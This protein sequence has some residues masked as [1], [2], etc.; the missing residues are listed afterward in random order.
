MADNVLS[1]LNYSKMMD[2]TRELLT[3]DKWNVIFDKLPPAVYTPGE[4]ALKF[5]LKSVSGLGAQ[6]FGAAPLAQVMV[7][8]FEIPPQPGQAVMQ[9]RNVILEFIDYED[10]SIYAFF[11]DWKAKC[12]NPVNQWSYRAE[13][14]R[15]NLTF[16][17]LNSQN[18]PVREYKMINAIVSQD[19]YDDPFSGDRQLVGGSS[20]IGLYGMVFPPTF[21]NTGESTNS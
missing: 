3:S 9:N 8:G 1:F 2:S 20:Q 17:R 16:Q 14:V 21:L 15:A 10:Q 5:R 18:V 7:R 11:T 12:C 4:E 19:N 6:V 13:E